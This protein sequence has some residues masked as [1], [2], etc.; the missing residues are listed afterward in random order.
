MTMSDRVQKVL[1]VGGGTAGWMTAAALARVFPANS[2]RIELVESDAIGTVGVGEATIPHI[3]NFN[4]LLGI[5]E[6]DFLRHTQ[7]TFK[8]GIEFVD[9]ARPG[10]RYLHPFGV[11]G[12]PM[13]A[14]PFHHYWL[15]L[16]HLERTKP[17]A[18][19]SLACVAASQ[20]RFMRPVNLPKSPLGQIVYAFHL[21]AGRY[22]KY[23]RRY[24][25]ERGVVRIEGKIIDVSL[26]SDDGYVDAVMLESGAG[27][28]A[29]LFIDCSGCPGLLIEQTL[30]TGYEEWT[31]YLPCNRAIAIPTT[32]TEEPRPY[33][34]ATAHTAGWQWR[35][36][37]QHRLGNGTVYSSEFMGDD[38]ALQGLQARLEGEPLADPN[39]L[40][41]TTGR[42][43]KFWNR[44]VI[45]IGLSSGFL[46]PLESTSIHLIQSGISKLVGLFPSRGFDQ[47]IVD[48]YNRQSADEIEYIRDFLILHYKQTERDDSAFW[49]YCRTMPIPDSL[50]AKIELFRSSGRLYRQE[51]ELFS[52]TSWLAVMLGQ[53]ITPED[54]HPVVDAYDS[55]VI[56]RH[57]AGL[58]DVI[59]RSADEMPTHAEFIAKHCAADSGQVRQ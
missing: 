31:E 42:R 36:P 44:N 27:L 16:K 30:K 11:Y 21:D 5:D 26:R 4:R 51:E 8:L 6:D 22:A 46:E 1:I 35:I 41:F 39:R 9:W 15:K 58:T 38:E 43:R 34:R 49:N 7:G 32:R 56:G 29:D 28:S 55:D 54:Y 25:E 52:E 19:Y 37:L 20:N 14:I 33:T 13:D 40:F 45:A 24:A 48:T 50:A 2:C 57:L 10:D 18:A 17:L 12:A 47:S 53:R 59:S 23:L 3:G